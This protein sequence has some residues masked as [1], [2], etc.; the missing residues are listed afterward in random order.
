MMETDVL[1]ADFVPLASRQLKDEA[2]ATIKAAITSLRLRPGAAIRESQLARSLGISKTPIRMALVR[3][4]N[5]GFVET[6]RASGTFIRRMTFDDVREV[7]EVRQALEQLAAQRVA[8]TAL[9]EHLEA[10]RANLD[11]SQRLVRGGGEAEAFGAVR[12]FHLLL[13]DFAGNTRLSQTYR[14]LFDHIV[15][16][17]NV[18]GQIPGRNERSIGEH[19]AIVDAL[20][21]HDGDR[22]A[23]GIAIH[24]ASLLDDYGREAQSSPLL[25]PDG[26]DATATV[27]AGRR[28][29]PTD[30]RA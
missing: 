7:F 5:E 10:L 13:V 19:R 18:C 23:D 6:R 24:L 29:E 17:G 11:D 15:R 16:I 30:G 1:S 8:A 12:G 4:E 28:R 27:R 14:S 26:A 20:A 21:A 9:P 25:A 22:A 2:Y 3:L